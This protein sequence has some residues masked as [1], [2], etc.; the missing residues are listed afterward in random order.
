VVGEAAHCGPIQFELLSG[1]RESE[2]E[3]IRAAMAFSTLL[4]FPID[5]WDRAAEIE[6]VLRRQGVTIPRDDIFVAAPALYHDLA[7]Y[8]DDAH[9]ALLRETGP[10][11]LRLA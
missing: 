10:F 7:L 8:A 2:V 9:F 4:D 5:C 6:K 3:D 1:A 11:P